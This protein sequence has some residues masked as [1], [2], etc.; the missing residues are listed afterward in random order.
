MGLRKAKVEPSGWVREKVGP[1]PSGRPSIDARHILPN[2]THTELPL[3][4]GGASKAAA[5]A[6]SSPE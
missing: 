1:P 5:Q 3:S 2:L 4:S 6:Q